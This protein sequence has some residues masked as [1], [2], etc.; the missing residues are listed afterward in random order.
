MV[1]LVI[2]ETVEVLEY[3]VEPTVGTEVSWSKLWALVYSSEQGD[4]RI[5]SRRYGRFRSCG[6]DC[7]GHKCDG[8]RSGRHGCCH[9]QCGWHRYCGQ[10]GGTGVMVVLGVSTGVMWYVWLARLLW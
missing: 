3:V 8:V 6:I 5:C 1:I 7:H 4:L 9:G 2:S 10:C